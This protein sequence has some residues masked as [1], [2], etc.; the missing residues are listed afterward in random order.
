MFLLS[1]THLLLL[2]HKCNTKQHL[3]HTVCVCRGIKKRG[4]VVNGQFIVIIIIII[5]KKKKK[6]LFQHK[7]FFS[8][9]WYKVLQRAIKKKDKEQLIKISKLIKKK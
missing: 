6:T 2:L 8:N 4:C 3:A 1:T 9:K 7:A 5:I